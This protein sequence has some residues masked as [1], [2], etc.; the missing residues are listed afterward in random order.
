MSQPIFRMRSAVCGLVALALGAATPSARAILAGDYDGTIESVE[1]VNFLVDAGIFYNAGYFGQSTVIANVEGGHVWSGHEVFNR[2]SFGLPAAPSLLFNASPDPVTAP[3]L[4]QVDYHATAVGHV[5]AGTGDAGGGNLSLLGAG[6]APLATLWSGAIATHFDRTEEN[7]GKF[8]IS[9]ESFVTPYIA[10][11]EGSLGRKADVIN[12]SW[13]YTDA[14]ATEE[15]TRILD[16]LAAANPT[17]ALVT[18]AGNSGPDTSPGGPGSGYNSITVGSLGGASGS[19]PFLS[20]SSFTSGGPADFYNPATNTTLTGVRAAV[21]IAAPGEQLALAAY[22][23]KSGMLADLVGDGNDADDLYF[24]FNQSGT[25]FASPVVAGGVALLKDVSHSPFYFADQPQSRDTRVIKSVLQ[26][27]AIATIGWDNGQHLED[28]VLVTTQALD[29]ST[30]AGRMDLTR[31]AEI[32]V[33][34]TTDVA[35]DGG[36]FIAAVGWDIGAVPL[37]GSNDYFFDLAFD[38]H[39]EL[40]V[41]LNWF[42]NTSWDAVLQT[43]EHLSFAN[44]NLEVWTAFDGVLLS[45]VASS[46][47]LYNNSEFVRFVLEPGSYGLRVAFENVAYDLTGSLMSETYGLAWLATTVTVPEPWHWG[48]SLAATMLIF[49][50]RRR[51]RLRSSSEISQTACCVSA[52]PGAVCP[53]AN[54]HH[55]LLRIGR[56]PPFQ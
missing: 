7:V 3:H 10:F 52:V 47:T 31:S 28:G 25:S 8:T 14:A 22:L 34:G 44:L 45:Q 29:Y 30:G 2:S 46:E 51:V 37:G 33:G 5:L 20:P 41:S 42:V 38:G 50:I 19:A 32:F 11:F 35:G 56:R 15:E 18:A 12:S 26:A 24:V 13:G 16:G 53:P 9:K 48:I 36:G 23:G 49:A 27:G 43:A 1:T 40:T 39:V 17:V 4:G 6:M 55:L 54:N 21:D